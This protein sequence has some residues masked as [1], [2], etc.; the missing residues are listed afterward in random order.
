[1]MS[2]RKTIHADFVDETVETKKINGANGQQ[3]ME[4]SGYGHEKHCRLEDKS[5]EMCG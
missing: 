1:M 5:H 2:R 4:S 3:A